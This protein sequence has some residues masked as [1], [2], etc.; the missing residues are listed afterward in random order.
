VQYA[1]GKQKDGSWWKKDLTLEDL[2]LVSPF[3][4]YLNS[5][6]PPSPICNPGLSALNAAVYP[7]ENPYYY[8]ISD[9][10][11]VIHYAKTLEEHN[12]NVAKYL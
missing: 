3:N 7:K 9:K 12:Q 8:Y 5:G 2:K 1:L 4:T 11:G 6:L 10:T